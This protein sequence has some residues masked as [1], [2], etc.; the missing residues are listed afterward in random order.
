[1]QNED[2]CSFTTT[3]SSAGSKWV[4]STNWDIAATVVTLDR[5]SWAIATMA[6]FKSPGTDGIYPVL[7]QK[8]LQPL[9]NPLCDIYRASLALGYLPQAWRVSRVTFMPK[10]VKTDYTGAKSYWPI[11]LTSFLLKG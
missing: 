3:P 9:L 4:P 1:M 5:I 6:P 2:N 10:P 11:S 8:G 7:L